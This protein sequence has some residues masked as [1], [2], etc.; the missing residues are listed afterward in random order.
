MMVVVI[1]SDVNVS[2]AKIIKTLLISNRALL[3]VRT[4]NKLYQV[5]LNARKQQVS[6]QI[7]T[8]YKLEKSSN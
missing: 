5:A 1:K 4:A 8:T 2:Q 7:A 6:Q 3:N